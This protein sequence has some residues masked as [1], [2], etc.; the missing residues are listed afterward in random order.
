M[1]LLLPTTFLLVVVVLLPS[2][3]AAATAVTD[4][5]AT[6]ASA[7]TTTCNRPELVR[8]A[9]AHKEPVYYFG[10]GSNMLREK[11]EQRTGSNITI[12]SMEPAIVPGHR[13][14]FNM[15]GFPPLEPGM[16]SL[17]PV[18]VNNNNDDDNSDDNNNWSSKHKKSQP[19]LAYDK[20]ECH[21]ALVQLSAEDYEKLMRTEGV[22]PH[23]KKPGYEEV[24]VLAYPYPKTTHSNR[25][26][27]IGLRHQNSPQPVLAVAL[28][29]RHHARLLQDPCPSQRYMDIL[30][31]GAKELQLVDEYQDFLQRHPV[32]EISPA[33]GKIA[34]HNLVFLSIV[35]FKWKVPLISRF[36]STLVYRIA[37]VVHP[38][39]S[40]KISRVLSQAAMCTI[41]LPGAIVGFGL[42]HYLR[43]T[44]KLSPFM[45]EMVAR[46]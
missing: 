21:G 43:A 37:S 22:G 9:L 33:L 7:I 20:D 1:L 34:V 42:L 17:E 45:K 23:V 6:T 11:I 8:N 38:Q 27:I 4:A 3:V 18:V 14:A 2:N 26:G 12:L 44:G 24:V 40:S 35:S 30:R 32:Q 31:K 5:S 19:L 10:L 46:Y 15:R 36:Q 25:R 28:R 13:L 39:Q 41:L 16:G 29:A